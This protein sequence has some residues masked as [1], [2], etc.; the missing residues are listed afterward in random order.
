MANLLSQL[1]IDE[2]I[3]SRTPPAVIELLLRLLAENQALKEEN[4]LYRQE[5]DILRA[6]EYAE[7]LARLSQKYL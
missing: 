4:Q 7:L 3:L 5:I 6:G 2:N 1:P